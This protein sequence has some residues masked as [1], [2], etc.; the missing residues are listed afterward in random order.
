MR[1]DQE[2]DLKYFR[3]I[4][5]GIV[6][7]VPRGIGNY[8]DHGIEHSERIE[9]LLERVMDICKNSGSDKCK[10]NDT[11]E[12]LLFLAAWFHDIGCIKDRK[13]HA[14]ISV[15]V[16]KK[17]FNEMGKLEDIA[18]FL[19][20]IVGSHSDGTARE[21]LLYRVPELPVSVRGEPVRLRYISAIFRLI[22]GCDIDISR[23][24]RIV[25]KI[26]EP[27]MSKKT[28]RLWKGHRDIA[29][30]DFNTQNGKITIWVKD[31]H[32][33]KEITDRVQKH[34]GETKEIL[35]KYDF[36]LLEIE[37]RN[38]EWL[39]DLEDIFIS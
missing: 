17:H 18:P 36:P 34:L 19:I 15:D 5:R 7:F 13:N 10:I 38:I 32:T 6:A 20:H 31:K 30:L 39:G 35:Q 16:I 23:C 27:E 1:P 4:M 9:K 26:L 12:Y 14:Q 33:T 2:F 37:V 8:T 3:Q 21:N 29:S 25:Y 22:D 28:K 11:E 24:P